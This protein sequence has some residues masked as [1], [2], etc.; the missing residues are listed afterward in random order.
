M[1]VLAH[2]GISSRPL[3]DPLTPFSHPTGALPGHL[4]FLPGRCFSYLFSPIFFLLHFYP[5]FFF[6]LQSLY[7]ALSEPVETSI[8]C[9]SRQ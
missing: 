8:S 4:A 2:A 5:I 6:I 3:P 7:G 1:L 9:S